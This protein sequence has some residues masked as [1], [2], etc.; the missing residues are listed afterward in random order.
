MYNSDAG[1]LANAEMLL[2]IAD[3]YAVKLTELKSDVWKF[4]A[5]ARIQVTV[6]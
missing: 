5:R 6:R 2:W 3:Q 4:R 1:M